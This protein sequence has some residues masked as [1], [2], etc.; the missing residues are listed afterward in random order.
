MN[1]LVPLVAISKST[2]SDFFI[3]NT[4]IDCEWWGL[5]EQK[6]LNCAVLVYSERAT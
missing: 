3:L 2:L 4:N 1:L 6:P 5:T